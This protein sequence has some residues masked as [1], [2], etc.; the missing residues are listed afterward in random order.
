[1]NFMKNI[2]DSISNLKREI[3]FLV[4]NNKWTVDKIL[5][6]YLF[7]IIWLIFNGKWTIDKIFDDC[8]FCFW[9]KFI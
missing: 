9:I 7:K 8:G 1:M 6:I 4:L 5:F 2:M 3:I